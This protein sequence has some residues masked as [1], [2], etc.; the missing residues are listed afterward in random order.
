MASAAP[1]ATDQNPL[2]ELLSAASAR[3]NPHTNYQGE[4]LP[5]EAF[6]Y[7]VREGGVLVDVRTVPEW[8]FVGMPELEGCKGQLLAISWKVYPAMAENPGFLEQLASSGVA[9]DTPLFFMCRGGGRSAS[10][11]DAATAAGYNYCFNV[12]T[13]FE[14]A[15]DAEGHRGRTSGWQGSGLPWKH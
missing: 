7:L 2:S 9:K 10:A 5:A 3:K 6:A 12:A 15:A 14:G 8:Q 11:A 13:G 4:I 1:L